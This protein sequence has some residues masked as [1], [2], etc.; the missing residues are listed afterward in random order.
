MVYIYLFFGGAIGSIVRYYV[1]VVG[2][3]GEYPLG[4][5]AVNLL[6]SFLLGYL[7]TI[8]PKYKKIDPAIIKGISTGAIGSFT[9]FS[10]LSV[11]LAN[12][13]LERD[14]LMLFSYLFGSM[15]GGIVFAYLGYRL[16][17]IVGG[18]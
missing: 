9:T 7:L 15:I 18:R 2:N 14:Y 12:L 8:F 1:S 6:G 17:S 13:M 11:E 16:A 3:G 4:T 5:L 10:A